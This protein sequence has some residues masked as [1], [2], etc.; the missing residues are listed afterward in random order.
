MGAEID[1]AALK[2]KGLVLPTAKSLKI[3]ATGSLSKSFTVVADQFTMDAIIAISGAGG[4]PQM[5]RR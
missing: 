3:Y 4:E 2:A 5:I 1:L